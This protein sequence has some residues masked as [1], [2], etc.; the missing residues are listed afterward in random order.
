LA[1]SNRQRSIFITGSA[2]VLGDEF[3]PWHLRHRGEHVFVVDTAPHQLLLNH[4]LTLR[5]KIENWRGFLPATARGKRCENQKLQSS[6]HT[7]NVVHTQAT[8]KLLPSNFAR[9]NAAP[10]TRMRL[11]ENYSGQQWLRI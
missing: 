8:R 6:S 2:R 9:Y 1:V 10:V 11:S 5:C 3:F 4:S 7:K